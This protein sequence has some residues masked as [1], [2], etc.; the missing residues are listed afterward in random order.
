MKVNFFYC[1]FLARYFC[2]FSLYIPGILINIHISY[3]VLHLLFLDICL[4]IVCVKIPVWMANVMIYAVSISNVKING[5]QFCQYNTDFVESKI[6]TS[7]ST[8]TSINWLLLYSTRSVLQSNLDRRQL[9]IK[10]YIYLYLLWNINLC[11]TNT[12]LYFYS[13]ICLILLCVTV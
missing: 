8:C 4:F 1:S 6:M 3:I 5:L 10:L 13:I 9:V 11:R 2:Y 12:D 7:D